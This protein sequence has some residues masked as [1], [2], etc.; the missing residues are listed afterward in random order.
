MEYQEP[1]QQQDRRQSVDLVYPVQGVSENY[2]YTDQMPMTSRDERNVRSFDIMTGRMRGSQRPGIGTYAGA[3][4]ANGFNKIDL[5]ARVQRGVNP[6]KW[7]QQDPVV[8]SDIDLDLYSGAVIVDYHVDSFGT[9]WLLNNRGEIIPVNEDGEKIE[10]IGVSFTKTSSA[11]TTFPLK[12]ITVDDYGNIFVAT[13]HN[14]DNDSDDEAQIIALELRPD[15]TYRQAWTIRPG[16]FPL[17][18]G[19]YG[20]DLYVWGAEH[21]SS[22]GNTKLRFERYPEYRFDEEPETEPNSS[23]SKAY[24]SLTGHDSTGWGTG[25]FWAGRMAIRKDGVVYGSATAQDNGLTMH[26]AHLVRLHPLGSNAGVEAFEYGYGHADAYATGDESYQGYGLDV[27]VHPEKKNGNWQVWL[28]GGQYDGASPNDAQPHIRLVED[29]GD[30]LDWVGS[31]DIPFTAANQTSTGWHDIANGRSDI[32]CG[33]DE[34]GLLYVPYGNT[35]T[36]SP[37]SIYAGKA[38]L[39][40]AADASSVLY[41]Y[42]KEDLG[43][44]GDPQQICAVPFKNPDYNEST[45]TPV[46]ADT[47]IVGGVHSAVVSPPNAAVQVRLVGYSV[48]TYQPVREQ[49]LLALSGGKIYKYDATSMTEIS[50]ATY[51]RSNRYVHATTYD[52][53][54]YIADGLQIQKY[55]AKDDEVTELRAKSFGAVPHRARLIEQWRGRLVCARTDEAPGSWRMSRMSDFEDWDEFPTVPD[56]AAAVTSQTS[57]AGVCPDAINTIIPYSDDV[58][59][60]GCDNSIWQLSGD[61]GAQ[62]VFDNINDEIGM[63]YGKP[64]CRDDKGRIWFFGSKGGL[65]TMTG[66]G[67]NDVASERI[68]QR[69]RNVDLSQYYVRLAYNYAEDGIH[70]FLCPF[71]NPQIPIDH[72]FY[73]KRSGSF[74]IDRFGNDSTF[75]GP[76]AVL[77][78]DGDAYD[79]RCIHL[80]CEDGRVRRWALAS[81]GTVPF[82]DIKHEGPAVQQPTVA[83]DSYVLMGPLAPVRDVS[84]AAFSDFTA[85]L[86]SRFDG[87]NY[88]FYASDDPEHLGRAVSEGTLSGGR[89]GTELIR[90]SG[91]SVFLKLRNASKDSYWAY[92]KATVQA[93]YAGDIRPV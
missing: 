10:S 7:T 22:A 14:P 86:S 23:W 39:V 38:V 77:V 84:E 59:W 78:V 64:W 32:R 8:E 6:Y 87:V 68:R 36:N 12:S 54:I 88:E 60:F 67:L 90:V 16:F 57:R 29:T 37:N 44:A 47:L 35:S 26:S 50:G 1:L 24:N 49:R 69:L 82:S 20:L 91:D 76:T 28:V 92:E 31:T 2:S 51:D 71:E 70:I 40:I 75:L 79:D 17:D 25:H 52:G 15:G 3:N 21:H 63:A 83:I 73:C 34:N 72:Y 9:T 11:G 53:C 4:P 5:L 48:P 45:P 61:P 56:A 41:Q 27:H 89:N 43:R 66:E 58:L 18:I 93:T 19:I 46:T 13:G 81:D 30:G 42:T 80:G 62:H 85:V 55:S 33:V 74:H 65:Y